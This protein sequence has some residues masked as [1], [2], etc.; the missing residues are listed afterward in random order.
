M[1]LADRAVRQP[2]PRQRCQHDQLLLPHQALRRDQGLPARRHLRQRAGHFDRRQR[3]LIDLIFV[4]LVQPL[5]EPQRLP[6]YV[7]VFIQTH[8]VRVEPGDTGDRVDH[9]LAKDQVRDLLAVLRDPDEPAVEVDSEAPHQRLGDG[10][11]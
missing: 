7:D 11:S 8:Q 1:G 9:L 6:L 2:A 10:D 5:R 4:V 3:A